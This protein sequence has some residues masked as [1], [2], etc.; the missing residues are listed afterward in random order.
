MPVF[1]VPLPLITSPR[2]PLNR[3]QVRSPPAGGVHMPLLTAYSTLVGVP[4]PAASKAPAQ[5]VFQPGD[6]V[7]IGVPEVVP[8]PQLATP[9]PASLQVKAD[10]TVLFNSK[11]SSGAGVV[12]AIAGAVA[13]RLSTSVP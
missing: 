10:P 13:S 6:D 9:E 2:S 4:L 12:T 3:S 11:S 8:A 5:N 1:S 7:S